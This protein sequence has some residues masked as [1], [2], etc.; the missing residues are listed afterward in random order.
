MNYQRVYNSIILKAKSEDRKKKCGTYYERH[1]ITPRCLD[2]NENKEN[3]VLL[4][5]KE[6]F[7]CH[8]LLTFIYPNKRGLSL[9]LYRMHFGKPYINI[10]TK[11]YE[12][13][14]MLFIKNCTGENHPMY[15]KTHSV[16]T[17][18]KMSNSRLLNLNGKGLSD[19]TKLKLSKALTN[20]KYPNRKPMSE[21]QKMKIRL[22]HLG[23]K[24]SKET[25]EKMSKS[26]TKQ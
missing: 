8:K 21:D 14:K 26:H 6:H 24:A 17:K 20:K 25:R 13:S 16:N 22:K 9:A 11:D 19:E 2:G 15:G 23:L 1:H 18:Q 12:Y 10:S 5:A 7:I 3:K 4:T